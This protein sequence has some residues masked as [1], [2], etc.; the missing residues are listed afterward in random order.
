MLAG[1]QFWSWVTETP[2]G[3][4]IG[5]SDAASSSSMLCVKMPPW[6]SLPI[7][8]LLASRQH[9]GCWLGP[10]WREY[11][12]DLSQILSWVE[13]LPMISFCIIFLG[14]TSLGNAKI[15]C[16]LHDFRHCGKYVFYKIVHRLTEWLRGL[17]ID[18]LILPPP[19]ILAWQHLLRLSIP[20]LGHG[21]VLITK[22]QKQW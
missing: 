7:T 10:C 16:N 1:S 5:D 20:F 13:L 14:F 11:N 21:L 12:N 3:P 15:K 19:P 4:L 17:K 18:F 2:I 6:V 8:F 9:K 22:Q